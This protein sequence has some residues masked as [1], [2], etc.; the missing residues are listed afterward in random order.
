VSVAATASSK[1]LKR[2]LTFPKAQIEVEMMFGNPAT[3][4]C[5]DGKHVVWRLFTQWSTRQRATVQYFLFTGFKSR[6]QRWNLTAVVS[7][8]VDHHEE[9]S[10]PIKVNKSPGSLKNKISHLVSLPAPSL[11]S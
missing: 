9:S 3:F 10:A 8:Q 5:P 11:S 1:T 7:N 2:W 6:L 4:N